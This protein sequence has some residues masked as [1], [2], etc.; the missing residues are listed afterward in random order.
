[1]KFKN[2]SIYTLI[3]NLS[4]GFLST[5]MANEI[6]ESQVFKLPTNTDTLNQNQNAQ[7]LKIIA[8]R[9]NHEFYDQKAQSIQTNTSTTDRRV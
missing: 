4:F 9:E 5:V 3:I 6:N 8:H 1:M 7:L 2:L